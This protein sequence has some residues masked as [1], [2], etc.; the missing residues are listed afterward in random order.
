ML[1]IDGVVHGNYRCSMS[2][3]DLNR[4]YKAPSKL[5][6]PEV[7]NTKKF[8]KAFCRE[9]PLVLYCDLH[10]HSRRKNIFMYGNNNP[11]FP[12]QCRI[13]PFIMSKLLSYFSY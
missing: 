3:C 10:G 12:E 13:Y 1:N 8:A 9:R 4:R 7:F 2:G 5:L 11:N 6:H